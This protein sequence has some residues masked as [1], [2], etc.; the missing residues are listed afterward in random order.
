MPKAAAPRT[1]SINAHLDQRK[2]SQRI[3]LLTDFSMPKMD[4]DELPHA[5]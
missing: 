4:G 2:I 3:R 5:I 1:R